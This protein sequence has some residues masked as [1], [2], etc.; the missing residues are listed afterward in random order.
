MSE[1]QAIKPRLTSR[2]GRLSRSAEFERVYRH[3]RSNATR[4]FVLYVFDR[5]SG[6]D[7]RLGLSVSR[8]VGGAVQRNHV[9]RLLREAY[10]EL[11]EGAG[12]GHDLVVVARPGAAEL[13]EREGLAGVRD[14]LTE[15][16]G[17]AGLS[18]HDPARP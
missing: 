13:A 18:D 6:G 8:K 3:G 7:T 15:L 1:E 12:D 16:F 17:K 14:A 5:P 10:A 2:G 9:K 11:A 4:H